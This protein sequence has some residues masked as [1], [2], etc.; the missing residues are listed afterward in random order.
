[1]KFSDITG[2]NDIITALKSSIDSGKLPHALLFSGL[3]G[4]GKF[5]TARALA[6]YLHCKNRKNGDSCGVC[7]SCIQ[8]QKHNNPDL[9]FVYPILKKEGAVI[10]KD[11]IAQWRDFI[12]E[13][14][15]MPPE[16]WNEF[17]KAGNSQPSI[18]V[19]ESEEII[20]RA[21]L[22]S[23]RENLKIFIIWQPEKMRMEAANK[24]LKIIEEPFEDTLFILVSNNES[25]ILPT[26]LSRTQRFNF[27][28]L[29]PAEIERMLREKGVDDETAADAA[30]IAGGSL[31]KAEAIA[32]HPD[33]LNDFSGLFKDV[34]RN[35]YAL[36]AKRLKELSEEIA[37]FGREKIIRFLNYCARLVRENFIYN[38]G[39][40]S[41]NEMTKDEASFSE[42]FAPFI[43]AGNVEKIET[44]IS[45]AAS[46]I[47]R[48]AN[49]K[50]VLFDLFLLLSRFVR[51]AITNEFPQQNK[52]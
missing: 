25:G 1:M 14:S 3:S 39:I 50:I 45:R 42:K 51:M 37:S 2:H 10:S 40:S 16:K 49:S 47:E 9:H 30:R 27:H 13:N 52:I 32:C 46:D 26:I 17:L 41:L 7:P 21:S 43:H 20:N 15:Y 18:Y 28:P 38:F 29:S 19:D 12:D 11:F 34:M 23:Y 35:A 22:S 8:H 6:Q 33:E 48:N 5:R 4:I 31:E 24:L 36:K 44:E